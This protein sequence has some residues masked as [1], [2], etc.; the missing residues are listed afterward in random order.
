M[1]PE[2]VLKAYRDDVYTLAEA[3]DVLRRRCAM[4]EDEALDWLESAQRAALNA[5]TAVTAARRPSAGT[6]RSWGVRPVGGHDG[7]GERHLR[8][9]DR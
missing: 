8:W 5:L 9:W 3:L 7:P 2:C 6:P 4:S 1:D